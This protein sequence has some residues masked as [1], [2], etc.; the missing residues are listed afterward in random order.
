M[1]YWV[2]PSRLT[3]GTTRMPA[4]VAASTSWRKLSVAVGVASRHARQARV[5]H[6]ILDV[7][8]ELLITPF[9]IARQPFQQEV[10]AFHLARQI[11]LKGLRDGA[12]RG[13]CRRSL[14]T[15]DDTF[16]CKLRRRGVSRQTS[17][18]FAIAGA[19]CWSKRVG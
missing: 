10:E 3:I 15:N 18:S 6:R 7:K 8:V 19:S 5:F 1:R 17:P 9:R 12:S 13:H 2:W 16:T 4:A 11:P 14:F